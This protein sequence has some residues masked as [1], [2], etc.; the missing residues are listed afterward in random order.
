MAVLGLDPVFGD[1]DENEGD[2][3][4]YESDSGI[5]VG[6]QVAYLIKGH[7]LVSVGAPRLAMSR[8]NPPGAECCL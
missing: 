6:L 2:V 3:V 5:P 8:R 4:E 7:W 1:D